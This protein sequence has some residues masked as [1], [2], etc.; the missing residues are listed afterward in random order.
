MISGVQLIPGEGKDVVEAY[1]ERERGSRMTSLE[2]RH[3]KR[4]HSGKCG[5]PGI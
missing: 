2:V 1:L 5:D 3:G 4:R